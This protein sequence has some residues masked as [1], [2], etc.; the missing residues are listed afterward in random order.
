MMNANTI[1][2]IE[3]ENRF[4]DF[5][6][7]LTNYAKIQAMGIHGSLAA[8]KQGGAKDADY[9]VML[10]NFIEPIGTDS[11]INRY[12]EKVMSVICNDLGA[13]YYKSYISENLSLIGHSVLVQDN[14]KLSFHFVS[15]AF[16]QK[17]IESLV[18]PNQKIDCIF[19][20]EITSTRVYRLWVKDTIVLFD[21]NSH[22]KKLKRKDVNGYHTSILP[23]IKEH[24]FSSINQ[25]R[26]C[27][28]KSAQYI[29]KQS[30]VSAAVL[31]VYALNREFYGSP[32]K[33]LKDLNNFKIRRNECRIIQD[34]FE[35]PGSDDLF[36][37]LVGCFK[38]P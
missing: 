29:L 28:G 20:T 14:K 33:I 11:E 15:L 17:S 30:I 23:Y 10:D 12:T 36:K 4:C 8:D 1:S 35:N 37:E 9:I 32:K 21:K 34:L 2:L 6:N 24:I 18:Y 31:L 27:H 7:T 25:Y 5:N 38:Q 22:L 3:A 26:N 19:N 13:E 16:C